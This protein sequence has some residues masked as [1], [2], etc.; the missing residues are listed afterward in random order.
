MHQRRNIIQKIGNNDFCKIFS[1]WENSREAL[2]MKVRW[3]KVMPI[4]YKIWAHF[5]TMHLSR[6]TLSDRFI[7]KLTCPLDKHGNWKLG[8]FAKVE[9]ILQHFTSF[10]QTQ[11]LKR[12]YLLSMFLDCHEG[13][14]TKR[15]SWLCTAFLP[16]GGSPFVWKF[17]LPPKGGIH[18]HN[19]LFESCE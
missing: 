4:F 9:A 3:A 13:K 17:I 8:R 10:Y 16:P 15:K 7:F 11:V 18:I 6:Q 14:T 2:K 5:T 19:N 12:I 1:R